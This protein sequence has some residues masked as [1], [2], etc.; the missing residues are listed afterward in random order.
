LYVLKDLTAL[1]RYSD[2]ILTCI[3]PRYDSDGSPTVQVPYL[4]Y[5]GSTGEYNTRDWITHG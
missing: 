2:S 1:C 4:S 5:T 3:S